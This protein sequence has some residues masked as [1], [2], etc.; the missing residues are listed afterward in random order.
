M[1]NFYSLEQRESIRQMFRSFYNCFN[2]LQQMVY[3]R[4]ELD[5][6]SPA[7]ETVLKNKLVYE[8]LMIIKEKSI[9]CEQMNCL[10]KRLFREMLDRA[11]LYLN[12]EFENI[13]EDSLVKDMDE[14]VDAKNTLLDEI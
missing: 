4:A 13:Y 11:E 12:M 2:D 7:M 6:M 1:E 8:D 5:D 3:D 9:I 14:V 10:P